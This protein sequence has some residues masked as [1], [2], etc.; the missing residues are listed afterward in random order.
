MKKYQQLYQSL[1]DS[2]LRGK[3][4]STAQ[5]RQAAFNN[6]DLQPPL[7]TLINKVAYEAYKITDNDIASAKAA[8]SSDDQ[9]FELII[10]AAVGQAS[11]QYE[12]ALAALSEVIK[13]GG[14][15]AC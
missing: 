4:A 1:I 8:G 12:S 9:L 15:Y 2:V 13:N 6:A 3:G 11:R 7:N 14:Q 10:C 5:Q